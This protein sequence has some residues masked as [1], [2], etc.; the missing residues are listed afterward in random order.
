MSL[1]GAYDTIAAVRYCHTFERDLYL[2]LEVNEY[3]D[4]KYYKKF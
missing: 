4:P 3:R 1:G 2:D